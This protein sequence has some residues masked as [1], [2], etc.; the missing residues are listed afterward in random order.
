MGEVDGD[1]VQP[2]GGDDAREARWFS[3]DAL[4]PLAFD[5]AEILQK[6]LALRAGHRT[7]DPA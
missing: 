5:H 7:A 2:R 3:L 6:A 1:R 4:P